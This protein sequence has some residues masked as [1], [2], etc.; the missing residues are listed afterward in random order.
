MRVSSSADAAQDAVSRFSVVQVDPPGRLASAGASN[1]GSMAAGAAVANQVLIR[2]SDLV[3]SLQ[4]Q[5]GRVTGLASV[6]EERDAHDA[7]TWTWE[8]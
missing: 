4:D 7:G 2:L 8:Q 5:S 6:I 3:S 1:V